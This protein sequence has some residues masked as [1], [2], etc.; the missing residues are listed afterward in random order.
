MEA[1]DVVFIGGGPGGYVGAI[2][3]AQR[4]ARVAVIERDE[5]GGVCLNRGCIPTKSLI[6][7]VEALR[8]ARRLDQFGITLDSEPVPSLKAM[9][10][11][12]KKIVQNLV[13]GIGALFK[14]HR[15]RL[16]KGEGILL[17]RD[18]IGV[19]GADG[20]IE[21]GA[22]NVVLASG[23]RPAMI[24]GLEPDGVK[25]LTSDDLLQRD[26]I[27][28]RLLVI[29]AGAIGCEWACIYSALG[30]KVTVVEMLDR[31]LPLEDEEIAGVLERE[32]RKQKIAFK[33]GAKIAALERGGEG[34]KAVLESG[35]EVEADWA[36]VSVGR[37]CNTDKLGLENVGIA[38]G[39]G[40]RIEVN[41]KMETVTPGI[42]AV[43]DIATGGPMLAHVASAEGIVA[44]ENITG[45]NRKLDLSAT[46]SCTFTHPEVA[47]VGLKESD[48]KK[49]GMEYKVGRFDFRVLGKA[50]AMGDIAGEVKVVAADSGMILGVHMIGHAVSD[51]IHEGVIAV[52][53]KLT[54][55]QLAEAIHAHPTLA[56]G[57]VE[58]AE[59]VTGNAI[60]V[61]PKK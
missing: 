9:H 43:G 18:R 56:E 10:D 39:K 8:T 20:E 40:G 49:S 58:A 25:V 54:V 16:I 32:F 26:I 60:H 4:G 30:A 50:Q 19:K 17:A 42:Y 11:R 51:L 23:S 44:A 12:R 6:A 5:L 3:A 2:R 55:E 13:R 7:S 21:I 22:R 53:Y 29:G 28:G 59:D 36:L 15:I 14:G 1:Y 41:E 38:P 45:A 31:L 57:M 48:A 24:P 27:P 37:A 34:V 52:K 47:S 61:A 46:P 33:L 35:D